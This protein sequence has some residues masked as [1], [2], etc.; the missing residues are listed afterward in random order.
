MTNGNAANRAGFSLVEL[1]IAMTLTAVIGGAMTA[2]FVSQS[3]L[4]ETQ[5]KQQFARGVTRSASNI[6][7]SEMRMIERDS[8]VVA[9]SDT[10]ITLRV[11]FALGIVCEAT[12]SLLTLSMLPIDSVM[13]AGATLAGFAYRK[14][15]GRYHY[16]ATTTV[17]PLAASS[18]ACATAGITVVSGG[19]KRTIVTSSLIPAVV[20]APV[21][22]YQTV[23]YHFS[24]ST[25]V[26]GRRGLYR[27]VPD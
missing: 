4:L 16:T 26:S 14:A 11:P 13:Y 24:A 25:A 23:R 18:T 2:L 17:L 7:M 8:G 21:L 1:L 10:S 5:E 22:L 9:A 20:G 19:V 27:A 12:A 3:R 15:D 6:I